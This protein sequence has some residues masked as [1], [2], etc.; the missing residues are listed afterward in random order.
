[1]KNHW[2]GYYTEPMLDAAKAPNPNP[3]PNPN[4]C[5]SP[6]HGP[7]PGRSPGPNPN[8]NAAKA[9]GVNAMRVPVGYWIMD[10][11][12]GGSSPLEYGISPEG[13][14]TGGLNHLRHMLAQLARRG[15]G[16]LV[17]VHAHPCNSAC[18]SDGQYCATTLAFAP[19]GDGI[20]DIGNGGLGGIRDIARC[21]GGSYKTSRKPRTGEATWGDVGVNAVD[22]LSAWLAALP[23]SEQV[24]P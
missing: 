10:A 15:M 12:V 8:A 19:T 18:V 7:G 16:A 13:F 20:G 5:P 14:V 3:D 23:P 24:A 11:P 9:L 21:G 4:P 22:Q 2:E 6:S 1:M 17:D